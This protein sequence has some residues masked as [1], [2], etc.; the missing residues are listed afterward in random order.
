[1]GVDV[2]IV[3]PAAGI[4]R[5]N[6]LEIMEWLRERW[7]EFE[8]PYGFI[9]FGAADIQELETRFAHDP[10]GRILLRKIQDAKAYVATNGRELDLPFTIELMI[11]Y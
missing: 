5:P 11:S 8:I 10:V 7:Q 3:G 4:A 2:I 9:D 1:M 6:S